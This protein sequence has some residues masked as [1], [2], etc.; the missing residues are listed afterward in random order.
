M[1]HS[2]DPTTITPKESPDLSAL[3]IEHQTTG[4]PLAELARKAGIPPHRLY[5]LKRKGNETVK[6]RFAPVRILPQSASAIGLE[7]MIDHDLRLRIPT[8]S[9]PD[10]VARLVGALR[11]C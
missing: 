7:L 8:G 5:Y 9:D 4:T 10:Q 11:S 3:L 6:E 1:N 2:T